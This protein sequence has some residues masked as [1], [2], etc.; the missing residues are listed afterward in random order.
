[1]DELMRLRELR[2]NIEWFT[3]TYA[4]HGTLKGYRVQLENTKLLVQLEIDRKMRDEKAV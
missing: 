4:Q 1:M 3:N 2:D